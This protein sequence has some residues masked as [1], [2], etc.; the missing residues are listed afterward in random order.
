[1]RIEELRSSVEIIHYCLNKITTGEIKAVNL[2]T[3]PSKN[4]MKNFMESTI[5]HFK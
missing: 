4:S 5:Q 2:K 3:A 1:V